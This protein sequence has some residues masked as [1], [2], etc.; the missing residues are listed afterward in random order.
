MIKR[1]IEHKIK[2]LFY[3]IKIITMKTIALIDIC[4]IIF[5]HRKLEIMYIHPSPK[6]LCK[7]NVINW[8]QFHVNNIC[9]N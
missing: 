9:I 5:S 7:V 2:D 3:N 4:C 8:K 6:L 1:I